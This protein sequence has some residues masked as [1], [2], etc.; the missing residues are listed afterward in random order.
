MGIIESLNIEAQFKKASAY[1]NNKNELAAIQIYQKLLKYEES[2]R[3]STIKLADLYDKAGK[4][5]SAI[6]LF[7]RYLERNSDDEEIIKLVSY[8]LV[9][10]SLFDEAEAFINKY[11]NIQDENMDFLKGIVNFHTNKFHDSQSTFVMFLTKYKSSEL[12]PSALFYLAKIYLQNSLFDDSLKT[13]KKSI[14]LSNN[15][16]ESYR[17]EAE[18]YFKKEMYYH[19]NE[20]INKALKLN[21]SIIG[22]RHFQIKILIL[23]EEINKAKAKLDNFVDESESSSELL[24]MLGNW[25]LKN[26]D[27]TEANKYFNI[28]KSFKYTRVNKIHN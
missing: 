19:A 11:Q 18:I 1:I 23:L 17:I 8:F 24:N 6:D 4:T 3:N 10:N 5:N 14:E 25:Y 20:S 12:V 9:R 16:A 28:A 27:I 26:N 13:I 2:E 15:N 7:N 22:W 21:P